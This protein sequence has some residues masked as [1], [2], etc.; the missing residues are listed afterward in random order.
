MFCFQAVAKQ[1][2]DFIQVTLQEAH[3]SIL[4]GSLIVSFHSPNKIVI[5][6]SSSI[7]PFLCFVFLAFLPSIIHLFFWFQLLSFSFPLQLGILL[8]AAFLSFPIR[9]C[10]VFSV[11]MGSLYYVRSFNKGAANHMQDQDRK[12]PSKQKNNLIFRD[13]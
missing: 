4:G 1:N 7:Y 11:S 12:R 9:F 8:K 2:S 6:G 10:L 13:S 5:Q 3:Q